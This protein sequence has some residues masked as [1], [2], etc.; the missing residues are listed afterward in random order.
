ML[1]IVCPPRP[2]EDIGQYHEEY[3]NF[4]QLVRPGQYMDV[5]QFLAVLVVRH[6][7]RELAKPRSFASLRPQ[8]QNKSALCE[9]QTLSCKAILCNRLL[10]SLGSFA[11]STSNSQH[12]KPGWYLQSCGAHQST[13]EIRVHG[14]THRRS[15]RRD[16]CHFVIKMFQ[17]PRRSRIQISLP[18]LQVCYTYKCEGIQAFSLWQSFETCSFDPGPRFLVSG[19]NAKWGEANSPSLHINCISDKACCA[20][21]LGVRIEEQSWSVCIAQ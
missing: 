2:R 18:K 9:L 21:K 17:P 1:A 19:L 6:R 13:N 16:K 8:G 11:A 20:N 12:G 4:T 3:F 5:E 14:R 10:A 15:V 7:S